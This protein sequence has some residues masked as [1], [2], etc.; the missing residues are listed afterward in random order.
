MLAAFLT[1]TL[2]FGCSN[3]FEDTI[4]NDSSKEAKAEKL[5]MALTSRDYNAIIGALDNPAGNY[6]GL[7]AREKY[8]L[9]MAWLGKSG[10]TALDILTEFF[11]DDDNRSTSDILLASLGNTAKNV[12][13]ALITGKRAY[14]SKTMAMKAQSGGVQDIDTVAGVAATLDTLMVVTLIAEKMNTI[15]GIEGVSFDKDAPNYI[16]AQV[17]AID[18][19]DDLEDLIENLSQAADIDL[20]E[21]VTNIELLKDSIGSLGGTDSDIGEK[22]DEY[23]QDILD[24]GNVTAASLAEFIWNQWKRN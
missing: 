3:I 16:G 10:F 17:E 5:E 4:A 6:G 12:D 19:K 2:A 20:A 15:T 23:T 1:L 21:L 13:T 7:S 14:Y 24:N 9:Q 22:F 11:K 8:L 18:D